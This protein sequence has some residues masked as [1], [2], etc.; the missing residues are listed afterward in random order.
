MR[1][2]S[3]NY[4][5]NDPRNSL[6]GSWQQRSWNPW[7]RQCGLAGGEAKLRPSFPLDEGDSCFCVPGTWQHHTAHLCSHFASSVVG[8]QT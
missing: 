5:M 8:R 3:Q 1:R 7:L 4:S 2:D 6:S